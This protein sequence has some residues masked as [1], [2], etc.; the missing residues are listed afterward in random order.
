VAKRDIKRRRFRFKSIMQYILL[1]LFKISFGFYLKKKYRVKLSPGSNINIKGPFLLLA[2]HCNNYD[3]LFLQY[4]FTRPLHFVVT[5]TVFRNR[6]LHGLMRLAGYIPKR[7]FLSDA[8][9]VFMIMRTV[10]NG[11]IV[12]I[13]PEGARSWD[14][15]TLQLT[16]ATFKLVKLLGI[17]VVTARIQGSYL[18]APRW[19]DTKRK[20]IIE[21]QVDTTLDAESIHKLSVSEIGQKIESALHHSEADWQYERMIPYKGKALAEGLERL[22]FICPNCNHIGTLS[23]SAYE[24]SC[25]ACKSVY[26]IDEYGFVH[27][28]IGYLPDESIAALNIWQQE[29]LKQY[30]K[31]QPE[32][33]VLLEE[34]YASIS[35]SEKD[36]GPTEKIASGKLRLTVKSLNIGELSFN[37]PEIRG[38]NIFFKSELAFRFDHRDYRIGFSNNR[39]SLYKWQCAIRYLLELR[40]GADMI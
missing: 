4:F 10:K 9:S 27:S 40:K 14:G 36:E 31:T 28:K 6:A 26:I 20:G 2:N 39:V 13:F 19:A 29:K 16:D 1:G 3:G 18:S 25:N 7:K 24:L 15:S 17:P 35:T 21:I 34:G 38:L 22:L 5:D 30:I 37:L 11:E 12:C 32:G 23:S 33:N 8:K